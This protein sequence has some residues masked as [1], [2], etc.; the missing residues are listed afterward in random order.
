[1]GNVTAPL[2]RGAS[3]SYTYNTQCIGWPVQATNGQRALNQTAMRLAPPILMVNANHDPETSYVWAQNLLPQIPSAVLLTRDGD[4]HTSYGL[5]GETSR[6]I[7][8][9]LV[10]GTLPLPGTVV[11]T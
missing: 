4:G 9:Y 7:D 5:F 11:Q 8:A 1:M 3:Q 6:L 2:V 10:N